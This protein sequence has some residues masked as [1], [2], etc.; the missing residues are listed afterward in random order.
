MAYFNIDTTLVGQQSSDAELRAI[1]VAQDAAILAMGWVQAAD[2]G[3]ANPAALVR[4]ATQQTSVGFRIYR[5]ADA[6]QA[7]SPVFLKLE[8]GTGGSAN[9]FQNWITIGTGT[10]G[11]GTIT[12]IKFARTATKTNSA[13]SAAIQNCVFS[14]DTNRLIIVMFYTISTTGQMISIEREKSA[15]GADVVTGLYVTYSTGSLSSNGNLRQAY[16]DQTLGTLADEQEP[17][18]IAPLVGTGVT[19]ADV[20]V[21]PQYHSREFFKPFGTNQLGYF[22][23]SIAAQSDITFNLYGASRTYFT[24]GNTFTTTATVASRGGP[25]GFTLMVRKV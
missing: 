21:Y 11:S 10:N 17:G 7:T 8:W 20:Y 1:A 5:M 18:I 15:L 19:G 4:N 23:S 3:Q 14:G 9:T 6:L 25:A 12:G 2:S 24:L 13:A 22:H 16:V